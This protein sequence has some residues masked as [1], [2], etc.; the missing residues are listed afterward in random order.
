MSNSIVLRAAYLLLILLSF[1]T[2]KAAVKGFANPVLKTAGSI[3]AS[4]NLQNTKFAPEISQSERLKICKALNNFS[5]KL[6]STQWSP[7][8]AEELSNIWRVFSSEKVIIRPMPANAS[9]RVLALAEPFSSG[10]IGNK[11]EA[12][13]FIRP[14]KCE[15]DSFFL[16]FFHELRHVYDF[17]ESWLNKQKLSAIELERRAFRLMGKISRETPEKENFLLLPKLWKDSWRNLPEV[18]ISEKIEMSVEKYLQKKDLYRKLSESNQFLDFSFLQA[19][20]DRQTS[21][22]QTAQT[23]NG[24]EKLP[25]PPALPKTNGIIPQNIQDSELNMEKPKNPRDEK[26]ILRAALANE[27]RLYYGMSNF[28]YDQKLK[29]EC[30]KKGKPTSFF[31]TEKTIARTEKGNALIQPI[32]APAK[33]VLLPCAV[34]YRNLEIDFTETFWASPALE[35]MPIKFVGFVQEDGKRLARYTVFRPDE[36]LYRQLAAEYPAINPFR[37][38]VGTIYVSPEEGQ[39]V[40]FWGGSFPENGVTGNSSSNIYGCY[41]V[42]TVRQKINVGGGIWM[43]VFIGASAMSQIEKNPTPFSYTV[44]FEN[45]R[46]SQTDVQILDDEA[47][48]FVKNN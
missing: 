44:S 42:T 20:T 40:K 1:S 4:D 31:T 2:S 19:S 14:N 26:E 5:V 29:L 46:Q 47:S 43:T 7:A 39:I 48:A 10:I 9:S 8:M 25:A 36:K 23:K 22:M 32:S 12:S 3:C 27:K 41:R 45:F 21:P 38:F 28:V 13:I 33:D 18:E 35:K 16:I 30:W 15:D 6:S 37:I 17:H 24:G 34:N 11:F